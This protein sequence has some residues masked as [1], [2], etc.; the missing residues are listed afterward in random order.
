MEDEKGRV[1][2]SKR[3]KVAR[4]SGEIASE[5]HKVASVRTQSS[6]KS[7][8]VLWKRVIYHQ[9]KVIVLKIATTS[10]TYKKKTLEKEGLSTKNYYF[11]ASGT[12]KPKPSATFV[13]YSGSAL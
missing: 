10:S 5:L 2:A 12:L 13:P 1:V 3:E 6:F 4:K 7:F 8:E 9:A 11:T